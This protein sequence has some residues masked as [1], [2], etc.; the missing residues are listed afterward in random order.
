MDL[1]VPNDTFKKPLET[2]KLMSELGYNGIALTVTTNNLTKEKLYSKKP[3]SIPVSDYMNLITQHRIANTKLRSPDDL[4]KI[5]TRL[6]IPL[7]NLTFN[8]SIKSNPLFQSYNLISVV[9]YNEKQ[10]NQACQEMEV[11][12]ITIDCTQRL[13]F[14]LKLPSINMA[15]SRGI[16]F[17]LTYAPAIKDVTVKRNIISNAMA[18]MRVTKGKNVIISSEASDLL[19]FRGAADVINLC[20]MLKMN[21]QVARDAI[22]SNLASCV[23]HGCILLLIVV[24]RQKTFKSVILIESPKNEKKRSRE[25]SANPKEANKKNKK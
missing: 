24:T 9:P 10:F 22:N 19:Q 4:F 15:I 8:Y 5:Y 12:I 1:L 25:E 7:T 13:P 17:E 20:F 14:Y 18:L 11:D 21:G 3:C 2:I 16:Y 23:V 6:H